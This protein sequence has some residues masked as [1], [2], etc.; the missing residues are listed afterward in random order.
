MKSSD[1]IAFGDNAKEIQ[2]TSG[3]RSAPGN[4]LDVFVKTIE[5]LTNPAREA[6]RGSW[7]ICSKIRKKYK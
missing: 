5:I 3:A 2:A 1:F 6:R 7:E 4:F